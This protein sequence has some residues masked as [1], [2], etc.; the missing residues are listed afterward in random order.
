MASAE[1]VELERLGGGRLRLTLDEII[2][3]P[4]LPEARK[5][6]FDRFLKVCDGN[7]FRASVRYPAQRN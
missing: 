2:N 6:Y 3:N 1:Q 4:R 5:I 7:R